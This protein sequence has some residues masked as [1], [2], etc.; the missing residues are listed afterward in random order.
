MFIAKTLL[1]GDWRD[2]SVA[3][4]VCCP[5]RGLEFGFQQLSVTPAPG[6]LTSFSGLLGHLHTCVCDTNNLSL[7]STSLQINETQT[8]V[9]LALSITGGE[10]GSYP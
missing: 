5:S 1:C 3:K 4:S 6:A 8:M 7:S 2:G 9:I 10:R